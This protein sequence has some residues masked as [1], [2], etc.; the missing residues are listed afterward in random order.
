MFSHAVKFVGQFIFA[1]QLLFMVVVQRIIQYP[2]GIIER[3]LR[4]PSQST[5]HLNAY[6]DIDW[7][8]CQD[9][10]QSTTAWSMFLGLAWVSQKCEKQDQV[11]KSSTESEY[12][13]MYSTFLEILWL[14]GSLQE[15]G[16]SLLCPNLLHVDNTSAFQIAN[17]LVLHEQ[18]KH[19]KVACHF[20]R[21]QVE[22][23]IVTLP[24]VALVFSL[25]TFFLK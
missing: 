8:A 6:S 9:T 17:S 11:S 4:F 2:Q 25:Q 1:P 5:I 14:H 12:C 21:E 13:A 24:H 19:I 23:S 7:A 10:R 22:T 20:V 18:T 16:I 3:G 15:L